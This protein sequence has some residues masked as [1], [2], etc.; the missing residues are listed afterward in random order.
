MDFDRVL[1]LIISILAFGGSLGTLYLLKDVIANM[2][3]MKSNNKS[4]W[5]RLIQKIYV[6][7]GD[8]YVLQ[9]DVQE[10]R[11]Q[12]LDVQD[13]VRIITANRNSGKTIAIDFDNTLFET[14]YPTII[15]AKQDVIDRAKEEQKNGARLILWTCREGEDLVD[16]IS[17]CNV[18]GLTFDAINDNL[19]DHKKDWNN[20][21]RKIWADEYWDDKNVCIKG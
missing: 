16:A 15:K 14:D 1:C 2:E 19:P 4:E 21:P 18:Y 13:A 20:N 8:R 6:I 11:G 9:N 3:K 7:G 5:E 17:A 12:I 10:L